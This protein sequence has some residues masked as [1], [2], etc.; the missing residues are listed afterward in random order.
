MFF[1]PGHIL[2]DKTSRNVTWGV[3]C[4]CFFWRANADDIAKSR[5]FAGC[6]FNQ[7]CIEMKRTVVLYVICM[8]LLCAACDRKPKGLIEEAQMT[9][10]LTDAYQLEGF[11]AVER[12]MDSVIT[13]AVIVATYDS[14]FAK[15]GV[16]RQQFD[17]SMAYYM[18]HSDKF[19]VIHKRVVERL[20]E[21]IEG[22]R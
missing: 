22:M 11:Y 4:L 17:E 21:R 5:N 2:N 20:D 10:L 15:H 18:R 8:L 7:S 3:G 1:D 14:I 13:D 6:L 12:G 16:T 9:E 19:E